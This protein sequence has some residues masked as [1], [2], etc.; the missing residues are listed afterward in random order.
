MNPAEEAGDVRARVWLRGGPR[1][2]RR[3]PGKGCSSPAGEIGG[4]SGACAAPLIPGTLQCA[5]VTNIAVE[6]HLNLI[7]LLGLVVPPRSEQ[8][9]LGRHKARGGLDAAAD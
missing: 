1:P 4:A 7:L 3:Y 5:A 9:P 6:R 2:R 8:P